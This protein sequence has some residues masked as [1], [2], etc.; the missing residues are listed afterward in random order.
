[1]VASGMTAVKGAAPSIHGTQLSAGY[2]GMRSIGA[3]VENGENWAQQKAASGHAT[4]S[5]P[6]GPTELPKR[7]WWA[8][9]KRTVREFGQDNI[10][11]WAAALTYYSVL[12]IFPAMIVLTAVLD[13][14]E[15]SAI[16]TLID[17]INTMVP[18]EGR[19]LLVSAIR[20]LQQP[21]GL[22][23]PLAI[24]G[25]AGAL[26]AASGYIRAFMRASNAIYEMP[27]GRQC[28]RRYH[29]GWV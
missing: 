25:L 19:G 3:G 29:C 5:G 18:G 12:S 26:W 22:A 7:S 1:M 23:G 28:G 8:V 6:Q 13:L 24:I 17:N 2:F 27:E 16:Q 20:E 21:Q 9:L 4:G 10:T 15:P 14:L 11:D